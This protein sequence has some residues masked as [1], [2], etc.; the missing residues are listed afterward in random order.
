MILLIA[1]IPI[2]Q[3]STWCI[4]ALVNHIKIYVL[5]RTCRRVKM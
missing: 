2:S 5:A 4:P 1:I 3:F